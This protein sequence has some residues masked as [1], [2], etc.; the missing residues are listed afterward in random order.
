MHLLE[1]KKYVVQDSRFEDRKIETDFPQVVT[2]SCLKLVY[3][4]TCTVHCTSLPVPLRCGPLLLSSYL[5]EAD[6]SFV[7][8]SLKRYKNQLSGVR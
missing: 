1:H 4:D 6:I 8:I 7:V 3:I 2:K 5:F